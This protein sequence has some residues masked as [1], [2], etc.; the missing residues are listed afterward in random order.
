MKE[1]VNNTFLFIIALV[2]LA[3]LLDSLGIKI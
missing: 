3:M 2:A 1:I